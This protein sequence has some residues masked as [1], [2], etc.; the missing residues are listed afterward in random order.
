MSFMSAKLRIY[1]II[2][3][4][5]VIFFPISGLAETTSPLV[6]PQESITYWKTF[7]ISIDEDPMVKEAAQVFERLLLGWEE[8]RIAPELHVVRSDKGP[9]A[10]SLDDGTILLSREAID[11]CWKI[12]KRGGH[13][14][15]ALFWPMN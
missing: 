5:F 6:C 10:A 2:S 7:E 4:L 3:A 13:D 15:L 8:T 12:G 9:W 11:V 1:S 14:R